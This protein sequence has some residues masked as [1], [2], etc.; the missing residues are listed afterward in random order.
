MIPEAL[1]MEAAKPVISS[2]VKNIITP[3][4]KK[5]A[6][7]IH[8]SYNEL[9]IPRG[10]HFEE[11]LFRTY[12]KYSIIN[13]LV[14]KNEQRLL[15][16]LYIP[17]T[18]T[19]EDHQYKNGKEQV[20]VD[21]YPTALMRNYNKILITDTAGMGKSTLTKLLFLDVIEN[22]HGIPIYIEMRRL[23]KDKPI[24]F[25]IQEQISSLSKDFDTK[26][27]LEFI[28][29]GGFIIFLDGYDEISINE[30]SV[31]TSNVQDFI[32]KAGNN[33]FIMT[34]RPEQALASFG[35]FQRFTINPLTK[36]EAFE[37]LR[38][39]DKQ[40]A[41]SKQLIDVLKSG[42]YEMINEFLKNPL[43]VSLLYAAF[44]YKQTIPL[45]KHI[46]YRQVYDAYFDSHD[47]SKGDSY[48]HD[49]YSHLDI[50]D[51]DRVLRF[52]GFKCI[53]Y[54][55]IEFEKDALL[56][57][58]DEARD[59][60]ADLDF[61]SSDFLNDL[62]S[63][64]PLFCQD[65]QYIKWVHKSLQEYFAAQFIFKDSKKNQDTLLNT[66]YKS[67]HVDNYLNLLDIY[68][69]IDNW[70]FVKN[71]KYPILKDYV[72][73]Y[74]KNIFQDNRLTKA[75]IEERIGLLFGCLHVIMKYSQPIDLEG[76][77][78][79]DSFVFAKDKISK[80]L[81]T[82]VD[83]SSII[84][85]NRPNVFIYYR[86]DNSKKLL[87]LI[88]KRQSNLMRERTIDRSQTMT[89]EEDIAIEINVRT[90]SENTAL[91]DSYT[92][93]L[94]LHYRGANEYLDYRECTNEIKKIESLIKRN[95]ES[96][97]LTEGL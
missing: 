80:L 77:N 62:L 74:S 79:L 94:D 6:E 5:F 42:Q 87:P 76:Q 84:L 51:F 8:T 96:I 32:S 86:L 53:K 47:L 26:L 95:E 82:N 36:K 97:D 33:T 20:K 14:F 85:Y 92:A 25:E 13:T 71:I 60:C 88:G 90:G 73:F 1:L 91:Y 61:N 49:K 64:V 45:K 70:G 19:K 63:A 69:D 57:I 18:I 46:F 89:I 44:D 12:K 78:S 48:I 30:R 75:Q 2:L 40:G 83:L 22:G 3:Q 34:S 16:D 39:Y 93:L 21:K 4:I 81:K 7:K 9:L 52:V 58:I 28:Q 56:H 10:E 27:L 11:Y 43:L 59:F 66:L 37:L 29:T 54:Q 68:F 24:L 72:A 67:P 50:D 65:G 35:D 23:K 17:L 55:K 31:V 41:T 38:K 15:K